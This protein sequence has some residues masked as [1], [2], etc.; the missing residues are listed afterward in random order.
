MSVSKCV[1]HR[2]SKDFKDKSKKA[3]FGTKPSRS[4]IYRPGKRGPNFAT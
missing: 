1:Y 2:N 3:N 4:L